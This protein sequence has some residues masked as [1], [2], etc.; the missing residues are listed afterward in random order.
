MLNNIEIT[1]K[2]DILDW[3]EKHCPKV[4]NTM[5]YVGQYN[6][7]NRYRGVIS[8]TLPFPYKKPPQITAAVY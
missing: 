8:E 2:Q 1:V 6:L 7:S 4:S 5:Q 3:L